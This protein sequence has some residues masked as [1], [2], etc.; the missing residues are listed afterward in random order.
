MKFS[1]KVII[2]LLFFLII[3]AGFI[4]SH[5]TPSISIR[6]HIFASGYPVGAFKGTVK[7]NK[8]QY[9]MDKSILDKENAMIYTIVGYNL[10]DRATGN[11][12]TNYKVKKI[13]PLYFTEDYGEC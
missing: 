4:I 1:R 8:G 6:T 3:A 12:I 5:A 2:I 10:Y 11:V 13:G 7:V 9:N